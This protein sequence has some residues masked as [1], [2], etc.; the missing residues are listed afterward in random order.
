MALIT[1]KSTIKTEAT[2]SP[3]RK[4]RY[5][6]RKEWDKSKDKATVIMVNP[7]SATDMRIDHTTMYVLNNLVRLG[8]GG[9]DI[10]NLYS[11]VSSSTKEDNTSNEVNDNQILQSARTS[12]H[13]I[14]AWGKLGDTNK[15][16]AKR[17]KEVVELLKP[18][19]DKL[20][21]IGDSVGNTGFHP[22]SPRV[23]EWN[24][25]TFKALAEDE[26]KETDKQEQKE[27]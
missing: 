12:S 6:L 15:R 2:F 14:V 24:L 16:V 23:H 9:C 1:E 7:A 11:R 17:Q 25:K 5:L 18:C 22:L 27:G 26:G 4:H 19:Q 13:V 20:F 3:D 8:F 21:V 10:V